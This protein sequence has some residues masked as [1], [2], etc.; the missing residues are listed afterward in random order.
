MPAGCLPI[1]CFDV[2][3]VVSLDLWW[4]HS[5]ADN[6]DFA[7]FDIFVEGLVF[8]A[9]RVDLLGVKLELCHRVDRQHFV[10]LCLYSLDNLGDSITR[11]VLFLL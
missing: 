2:E 10:L 7:V 9:K 1:A 8:N 4:L 11:L 3:K 6:V 5:Q